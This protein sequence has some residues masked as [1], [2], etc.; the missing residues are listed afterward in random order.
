MKIRA[1]DGG[2]FVLEFKKEYSGLDSPK[3]QLSKSQITALRRCCPSCRRVDGRAVRKHNVV[4]KLAL[5]RKAFWN[6]PIERCEAL[7]FKARCLVWI[8]NGNR[9]FQPIANCL[10]W[11]GEVVI[12]RD[13]RKSFSFP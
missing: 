11:R 9:L 2:R 8:E 12:A 1:G 3:E 13:K 4:W 6:V 5:S 10:Y 7:E